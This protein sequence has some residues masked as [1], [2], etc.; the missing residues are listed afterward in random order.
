MRLGVR[1]K[2]LRIFMM[3]ARELNLIILIRQT[4]ELSLEYV[5]RTGFYPKPAQVKAKTADRNVGTTHAMAKG[6][7]LQGNYQ[8]GG[9]VVVPALQPL[10]FEP[11]KAGKAPYFWD[12]TMKVFAPQFVGRPIDP[13]RPETYQLLGVERQATGARWRW[14]V[15][16]D[17]ASPHFGALK[18][19]GDGVPMSYVHGDYDLK[20]VIVRGSEQDNRRQEG[21]IDSVKNFTPL[22]SGLSFAAPFSRSI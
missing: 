3:I 19:G 11:K 9:L 18:I 16:V 2:D 10:S 20:D 7:I 14:C 12:E 17:P 1:G 4:N 5:G 6:A 15:D 8:V 22:L 21:K 13:K